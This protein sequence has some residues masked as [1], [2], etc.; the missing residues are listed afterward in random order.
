MNVKAQEGLVL[1]RTVYLYN[2]ACGN[3]NLSGKEKFREILVYLKMTAR[4][5]LGYGVP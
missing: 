1:L 5:Q 2:I 4:N 3:I